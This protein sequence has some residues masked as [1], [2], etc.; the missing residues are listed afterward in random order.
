MNL[1]KVNIP[2]LPVIK[3]DIISLAYKTGIVQHS[4]QILL[5]TG[6]VTVVGGTVLACKATL[7]ANDIIEELKTNKNNI[8]YIYEHAED[9]DYDYSEN[10]KNR[11]LTVAY[12]HMVGKFIKTYT[13][14]VLTIGAG[15]A[16]ICGGH[17]ILNNRYLTSVVAYN[18]LHEMYNDYREKVRNVYGDE[19]D[20]KIVHGL[21][22]EDIVEKEKDESGKTKNVK[23]KKVTEEG[24]QLS[25]FAK[26]FSPSTT[27]CCREPND[28][29]NDG[30]SRN[31]LMMTKEANLSFLYIIQAQM[32]NRLKREGF[33]FLNDVYHALGYKMTSEGQRYG[34][35]YPT[36]NEGNYIGRGDGFVSFGIFDMAYGKD[37]DYIYENLDPNTI[38]LDFN[39][40]GD[41]VEC[42][43]KNKPTAPISEQ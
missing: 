36:D 18:A 34:W 31:S 28:Y 9:E 14:A 21:L 5:A 4:P 25:P 30:Y 40:D 23:K 22:E 17:K 32:N 6:I 37:S 12:A 27:S 1:P 2:K 7:K 15:I 33:L 42:L 43:P 19:I 8:N 39:V 38:W 13:P 20:N 35:V 10:D 11:D 3:Q 26:L 29:Y 16:L 24:P 41:I